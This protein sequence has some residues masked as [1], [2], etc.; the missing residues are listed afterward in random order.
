MIHPIYVYGQGGEVQ[1][2]AGEPLHQHLP[3]HHHHHPPSSLK[4]DRRQQFENEH[5][6][7]LQTTYATWEARTTGWLIPE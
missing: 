6:R 2:P 7:S 4:T 1:V 5:F 3:A